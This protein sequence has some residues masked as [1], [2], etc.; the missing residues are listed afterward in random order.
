M[1]EVKHLSKKIGQKIILDDVNI[2]VRNG[3]IY[4]IIGVNGAGKTTLIRHLIGSYIPDSGEVLVD[5]VSVFENNSVKSH[6][7]YIPDEFPTAFGSNI[8]DIAKFYSRLYPSWSESRYQQLISSFNQNELA[9]FNQFSKGMKKQV[10][11]ILALSIKPDYLIMDE[12]FDGLDPLISQ[13]IWDILVQDVS[14]RGMT[15][16]ISSHHLKELDAMCDT[17]CLI[18][19]GKVL[20]EYQME[21]LKHKIHK[22]QVA[23]HSEMMM[24]KAK[25]QVRILNEVVTGKIHTWIV[26]GE[27]EEIMTLIENNNPLILESLPLD[28]EEIFKYALGGD[29]RVY[30]EV[31]E[32]SV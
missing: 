6:I 18:D 30:E 13:I 14:E 20:F 26:D 5:G 10:L 28:L 22:I 21:T 15:V 32:Q 24:E 16:F 29:R 31:F 1:I 12:P 11:F 7:V 17:V 9:N 27:L 2:N 25:A 23:F 4:G 3:S 19:K 8:R